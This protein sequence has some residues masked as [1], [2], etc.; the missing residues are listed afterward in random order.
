VHLYKVTYINDLLD[1]E[2]KEHLLKSEVLSEL[3]TY[4][5]EY[6]KNKSVS[7]L[8]WDLLG[9]PTMGDNKLNRDPKK[10]LKIS[11]K[12]YLLIDAV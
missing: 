11:D 5:L 10:R 3:E 6:A 4:A 9:L 1:E 2:R 12:E 8:K 7:N